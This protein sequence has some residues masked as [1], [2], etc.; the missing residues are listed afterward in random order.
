MLKICARMNLLFFLTYLFGWRKNISTE[1]H[2]SLPFSFSLKRE[3]HCWAVIPPQRC[4]LH[5]KSLGPQTYDGRL[6]SLLYALDE[7]PATR[8]SNIF[9]STSKAWAEID[10]ISERS[11]R[12]EYIRFW[13][14]DSFLTDRLSCGFLLPWCVIGVETRYFS[15]PVFLMHYWEFHGVA[16][17]V[18][19]SVGEIL[20]R[21]P[22]PDW[23]FSLSF[24]SVTTI[25]VTT[26]CLFLVFIRVISW[27][28]LT[29]SFCFFW[30]LHLHRSLC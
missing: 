11:V 21:A 18:H 9:F 24:S 25:N 1:S 13:W 10:F 4:C 30:M 12:M 26:L 17:S 2:R 8:K 20:E 5:E 29:W 19:K 23:L 14:T 15:V 6:M 28:P 7:F 27:S 3:R 22:N 16:S